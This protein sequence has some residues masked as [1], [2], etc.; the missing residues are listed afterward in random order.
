MRR[1]LFLAALI[2]PVFILAQQIPGGGRISGNFQ[3][4]AQSYTEDT[5]IGAPKVDEKVGMN[6]FLNL[7]YQTNNFE[8]GIRYEAYLPAMQGIDPRY[9]GQ[10]IAHRYARYKNE[11]LDIT[12]GDFYE[13][14]GSGLVLRS[15]QEWALGYDN[16]ID[17]LRVKY[18]PSGGIMLTGII[19]RQRLFW[20][21]G[22]GLIRG[23]DADFS[24]N[25]MKESW[26]EWKTRIAFGGSFVGKYQPD[27]DPIYKLP[28]NVGSFAGRLRLSRGKVGIYSE[29]AYKIN[30][31]S[32]VNNLIYKDGHALLIQTNYSQKGLGISLEAK[33]IDNMS[34]RS[35]RSATGP[36]LDINYLPALTRQ[37]AYA[38]SSFYPYATQ[39][40]GEAA[41]QANIQYKIKKGTLL[42]GKYGTD[43]AI[44]ASMANAILRNPPSDT[45]A[46]GAKG[47]LG[48][49]SSL[50]DIGKEKYFRD[51]N[52]EIGKKVNNKLKFI[53]SY[54]NLLYNIAVIE[55]HPGEPV[56][57]AHIGIADITYKT[58]STQALHVEFQ[59]MATK[60]DEGNWAMALAEYTW[61]KYFVALM[62]VYN[63]GNTDKNHR[64]HYYKV[65]AGYMKGTSQISLSYG[66]QREGI[67]CVG[68]VCRAVP[69][70]NGLLLTITSSF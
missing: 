15:Y 65:A 17:G 14:F 21:K 47:T 58:T 37:H 46:I 23:I 68:G 66:K 62:D 11:N 24:L 70:A 13:Q 52:V 51:V 12:A 41:L 28:E 67:L 36:I 54:V 6:G 31:P 69:A 10:G 43:V 4:D 39:P 25:E 7:R 35:D 18:A 40:N 33:R 55:G 5:L 42:G 9:R 29:Y 27:R 53:V 60:Q 38:L 2:A 20:D 26:G 50:L 49:Q 3:M 19:G 64:T 34:F 44:N 32:A 61:P 30:D 8:A 22:P 59:H 56:V 63:Y 57:N 48:Y 45:S 1:I 16:A